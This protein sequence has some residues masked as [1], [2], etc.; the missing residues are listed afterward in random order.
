MCQKDLLSTDSKNTTCGCPHELKSRCL[1]FSHYHEHIHAICISADGLIMIEN[2]LNIFSVIS[3]TY[4]IDIGRNS[5]LKTHKSSCRLLSL[6]Q[7]IEYAIGKF[8]NN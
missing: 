1:G 4:N 6:R 7:A 3:S 5:R 2:I 8:G